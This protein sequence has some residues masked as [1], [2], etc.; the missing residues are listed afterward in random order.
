MDDSSRW[1]AIHQKNF[2]ENEWHSHFAEEK[3]KLFPRGC[4][5]VE[6]GS[7]TGAD[8]IYF[9]KK[10]HSVVA[11]DIS[12]FALNALTDRAK[13]ESL[14]KKLVTRQVDFGLQ[15]IPIKDGSAD[16]VYSRISLNY[17]GAK[18]TTKIFADISRILKP[19]GVAYLSFK[20]PD[21]AMEMEFFEK[22]SVVY[23]P[24]VF[25]EGDMLR[26]RFTIEQLGN[27]LTNAGISHFEVKPFQEDLGVK[28]EGHHPILYVNEIVFKKA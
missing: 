6:L 2:K 22:S 21:D 20:S 18:H 11:F 17:F 8:A 14:E 13:K 4:L 9:L 25:I 16:V 7:G 24:N 23:E 27:M 10:G 5:V 19:E 28:G 15:A 12:E 26:S 3:E 1:D